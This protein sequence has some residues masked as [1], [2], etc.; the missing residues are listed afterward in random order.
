MSL[1]TKLFIGIGSLFILLAIV[2]FIF[3]RFF[4]EKDVKSVR[5]YFN[6]EIE[7]QNNKAKIVWQNIFNS[8]LDLNIKVIDSSL[9][10]FK[11]VPEL[12]NLVKNSI[13]ENFQETTDSL[14]KRFLIQKAALKKNDIQDSKAYNFLK[15]S[16]NQKAMQL[17]VML[18]E[19]LNIEE[20][21][22][23]AIVGNFL[24]EGFTSGYP[25]IIEGGKKGPPPLWGT[26]GTGYGWAQWTNTSDELEN[27]KDRLN[28]FILRLGGN[29]DKQG[30]E[31]LDSDNYSYVLHEFLEDYF[32]N[33][34]L[35]KLRKTKTIDEATEVIYKGYEIIKLSNKHPR[36]KARY[37]YAKKILNNLNKIKEDAISAKASKNNLVATSQDKI[38]FQNLSLIYD[39]KQN[40]SMNLN[41]IIALESSLSGEIVS[42]LFQKILNQLSDHNKTLYMNK[43]IVELV[44]KNPQIDFIQVNQGN[45]G[46]F[47]A[48]GSDKSEDLFFLKPIFDA[49]GYFNRNL[50]HTN[51][52]NS[53]ALVEDSLI[54][55]NY[56]AN[57]IKIEDS[58]GQEPIYLTFGRSFFEDIVSSLLINKAIIVFLN[59]EGRFIHA[60]DG[61]NHILN[62][63][64]FNGFPFESL[65]SK[66]SGHLSWNDKPFSYFELSSP[67]KIPVKT[68]IMIPDTEDP[69]YQMKEVVNN[70]MVSVYQMLSSQLLGLALLLLTI[71][72]IYIG[73]FSKRIT[74]PITLLAKATKKVAKGDFEHV[75][76]PLVKDSETEISV[77]TKGFSDMIAS[78]QDRE[79]IRD[80]LD[81]V[82]SKEIAQE[83]LKGNVKLGGESKIVTILFADIRGFTS[84]TKEADPQMVLKAL[85]DYITLMTEVIEQEGGV[86]DKY[87]GD[88]IMALYGAPINDQ[89]G[90]KHAVTTAILMIKRLKEW[91]E[92]RK[93]KGLKEVFIGIGI[94]TGKVVAGNMGTMNRLNYTVLGASVNLAS[95]LCSNAGP[96]EIRISED[97]LVGCSIK[98]K[99][100]VEAL[101]PKVYKGF[102][103]PI[104]TYSV[105]GFK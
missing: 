21:Q 105:K 10:Y 67:V 46:F 17:T 66:D 98:E 99:L 48:N 49:E 92:E 65:L 47:Y 44:D 80:L 13:D 43:S 57:T 101:E 52:P 14:P 76:L 18:S 30:R 62:K 90:P 100:E 73:Y 32:F 97:T 33:K 59:P 35:L 51:P 82:V 40:Q 2:S 93:K 103:T 104:I 6:E 53:I 69:M 11:D 56:M 60:L 26:Q 72:L 45:R 12:Q 63:A 88:A 19:D 15:G 61:Q 34:V 70:N 87:I 5:N 37:T 64:H 95:R 58:S 75:D 4:I 91:N 36:I 28:A 29:I 78:L 55:K 1:R 85:N 9:G 42:N 77:L 50:D 25:N 20:F 38:D 79:K 24:A 96:M 8:R 86:I 7:K 102:E 39:L 41:L 71:A 74:H 3:P 81:K 68:Y 89:E 23:A 27:N 16:V 22:A 83:I 94:H 54:K 31:A 84:M